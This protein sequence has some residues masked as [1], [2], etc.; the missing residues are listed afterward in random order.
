MKIIKT[1]KTYKCGLCKKNIETENKVKSYI[2]FSK[3]KYYHL[4]C[5]YELLNNSIKSNENENK[6]HWEELRRF[7]KLQKEMKEEKEVLKKQVVFEK[8]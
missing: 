1:K 6:G 3:N 4:S 7:N 2:S 8:L 5:Y